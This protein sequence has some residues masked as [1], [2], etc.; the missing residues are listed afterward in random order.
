MTKHVRPRNQPQ[1]MSAHAWTYARGRLRGFYV[2]Y[3]VS[4]PNSGE[5]EKGVQNREHLFV[6]I[7]CGCFF[8]PVQTEPAQHPV[9]NGLALFFQ[10][11]TLQGVF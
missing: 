4:L 11:K 2:V 7:L 1:I 9:A 5:E 6:D 8:L 3:R 10:N